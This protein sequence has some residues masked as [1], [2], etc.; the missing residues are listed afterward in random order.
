[1]RHTTTGANNWQ[2]KQP[3]PPILREHAF[4]KVQSMIDE[5]PEG[6]PHP[7]FGA[8]I[9]SG[10]LGIMIITIGLFAVMTGGLK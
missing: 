2:P 6:E 1:M 3:R 9:L 5:R 8:I 4:G 7:L 10:L